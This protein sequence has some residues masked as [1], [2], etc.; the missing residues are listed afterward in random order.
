MFNLETC[1]LPNI[2]FHNQKSKVDAH[3]TLI[4]LSSSC[5]VFGKRACADAERE[6]T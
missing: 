6:Y 5:V 3:P 2:F 4:D 1:M